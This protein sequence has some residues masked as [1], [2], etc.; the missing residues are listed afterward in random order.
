M[1][2]TIDTTTPETTPH[3][4]IVDEV[5]DDQWAYISCPCGFEVS[6][7]DEEQNRLA[8]EGHDC[9]YHDAVIDVPEPPAWYEVVFAPSKLFW[10]CVLAYI[11]V[12]T[13]VGKN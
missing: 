12:A 1:G 13:V 11:I 5:V 10:Y 6:G 3:T 8:Y 4:F 9:D 2:A 7:R